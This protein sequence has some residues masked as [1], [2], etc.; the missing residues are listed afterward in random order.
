MRP[1]RLMSA[2]PWFER[3]GGS[4]RQRRKME[5]P[6]P[7]PRCAQPGS[8]R[9]VNGRSVRLLYGGCPPCRA[10][11]KQRRRFSC[12]QGAGAQASRAFSFPP[13]EKKNCELPVKHPLA[14]PQRTVFKGNATALYG[15]LDTKDQ[16]LRH[17]AVKPF[18]QSGRS[19]S[20]LRPFFLKVW[21]SWVSFLESHLETFPL[22][23][24]QQNHPCLLVPVFT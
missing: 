12:E 11:F 17:A 7:A 5:S 16:A 24:N 23:K 15:P 18:P 14:A 2:K 21:D 20:P 22:C 8:V 10:A 9:S 13:P 3:S 19:S 1:K 6:G 4:G